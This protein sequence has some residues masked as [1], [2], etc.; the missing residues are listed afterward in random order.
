VAVS[1]LAGSRVSAADTGWA[2]VGKVGT[3]GIGADI[4]RV[5]VPDLLNL[6][7]GASFFPYSRRFTQEGIEYEGKLR[8]GA[9]PVLLDVYPFRNWFRLEGGFLINLN[10]VDGTGISEQGQITI[11][12][13][14]YPVDQLGQL[15]GTVKFNRVAPY[16]GLGF[17]NPIK[18]RKHWGFFFDLGAMYHGR[19]DVSLSTTRTPLPQLVIDLKEE[20]LRVED[21]VKNFTF[22]PIIQFGVSYHF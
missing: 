17:C 7:V 12:D 10:Q 15:N 18:K 4:H 13:R 8:L 22:F 19:P 5:L 3:V 16:F 20:E 6:R 11:G 21:D 1:L 9:V 14:S 2:V